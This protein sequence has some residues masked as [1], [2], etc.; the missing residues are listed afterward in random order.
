MGDVQAHEATEYDKNVVC[1]E[2]EQARQ[3]QV[4]K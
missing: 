1:A 4:F 2:L 3:E